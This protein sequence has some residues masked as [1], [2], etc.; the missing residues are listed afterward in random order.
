MITE[1]GATD[2]PRANERAE[3]LQ[4]RKKALPVR[5]GKAFGNFTT[6][7]N[8]CDYGFGAAAAGADLGAAGLGAVAAAA[9]TG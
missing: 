8:R 5:A 7:M 1:P 2:K 4:V 3:I 9:F 6:G